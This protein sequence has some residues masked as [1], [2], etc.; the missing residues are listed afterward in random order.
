MSTFP[1]DVSFLLFVLMC[2]VTYIIVAIL[3]MDD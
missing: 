2:F 3:M 1:W